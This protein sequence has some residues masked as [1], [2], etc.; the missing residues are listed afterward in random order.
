[1]SWTL[2]DFQVW[3]GSWYHDLCREEIRAG[4]LID[5]SGLTFQEWDPSSGTD[6]ESPPVT[7]IVNSSELDTVDFHP[8]EVS[9]LQLDTVTPGGC[10]TRGETVKKT[11][12]RG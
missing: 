2:L 7:M 1:V 4:L 12:G 3:D 10:R 5:L 6:D 11:S 8:V 9:P